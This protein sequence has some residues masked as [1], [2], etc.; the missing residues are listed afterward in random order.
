MFL[1]SSAQQG[2]DPVFTFT[3]LLGTKP[4]AYVPSFCTIPLPKDL[5]QECTVDRL[6]LIRRASP[7]IIKRAMSA[8][9]LPIDIHYNK[10]LDWLINRRHCQLQ[11]QAGALAIR[12]KINTA[13]QDMPPVNEITELLRGTSEAGQ[14]LMRNV[15]YEIPAL[16]RQVAKCQQ[17]Q[18]DCTRKEA[19]YASLT[20]EM[21]DKYYS[22]CR[23]MGIK[24]KKVKAELVDLVKDMST[25]YSEIERSALKLHS[26]CQYYPAF[27][28]FMLGSAEKG[29]ERVKLLKHFI[30]KG[31]TTTYEWKHSRPPAHLE[32][33][34]RDYGID[35]DQNG[36]NDEKGDEIDWGDIGA[37]TETIDFDISLEDTKDA[38]GVS[39]EEEIDWGDD[40]TAAAIEVIDDSMNDV[41]SNE[42]ADTARGSDALTILDNTNTRNMLINELDELAAFLTQRVQ[43]LSQEGNILSDS[44]FSSAPHDVQLDLGTIKAML[45]DV[46]ELVAYMTS[47][48]MQN[49]FLIRSS[50]SYVHRMADSLSKVLGDS[51]KMMS[52]SRL[53]VIR[54]E[55]ALE[56][57][58]Q[59]QPQIDL[60]R[61]RTHELQEQIEEEISKKYKGRRVNIMGEINAI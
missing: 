45:S 19:E 28:S 31:N 55:E 30:D 6:G 4:L 2:S 38:E 25:L 26:A 9:D 34:L 32:E 57:E 41:P 44:Q 37:E 50:P 5:E 58:K 12:E 49:L 17:V 23:Q 15:N 52:L 47:N 16:R 42:D 56:E 35:D 14:M 33:P 48:K 40:G 18:K 29:A 60:L 10:L 22:S 1:L 27:V 21:K 11:W 59:I 13:I 36:G 20:S 3:T 54:S 8:D 46:S 61:K 24:G 39:A 51:E 53:M 43:E 7:N